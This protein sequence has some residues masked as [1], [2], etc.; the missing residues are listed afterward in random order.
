MSSVFDKLPVAMG[1]NSSASYDIHNTNYL[2]TPLSKFEHRFHANDI[3][4][5]VMRGWMGAWTWLCSLPHIVKTLV[6]G[7]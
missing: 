3:I 4:R 2:G 7:T 5:F 6:W 1:V